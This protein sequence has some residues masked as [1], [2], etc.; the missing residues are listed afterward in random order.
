MPGTPATDLPT[1]L[2][3]ADWLLAHYQ[4]PDVLVLDASWHLPT[5]KRDGAVEWRAR[6]IPGS[7]HFDY[8]RVFCDTTNPLPRMMP[9]A[10]T[11]TAAA[12]ALGLRDDHRI[13]VYD[14]NGLFSSPRAWWMLRAAGHEQVAVLDGGLAAWTAAGGVIASGHDDASTPTGT[15]T[16]RID[17]ARFVTADHVEARLTDDAHQILDA[18]AGARF[19]AAHMP[20]ASNLPYADLLT[21]GHLRPASELGEQVG[22]LLRSDQ[23]LTCS[24]GSGVTACVIALAAT[25]AGLPN[26]ISIYDGS[27]SEWGADSTRPTVTSD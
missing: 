17:T 7:R 21:D 18:R 3:S 9:D 19:A 15:F 20:G 11:F 25:A 23:A 6:R 8:D 10:D 4:R 1:P 26:A 16:A 27:W 2:V 24:C 5:A 12:R 13:V 22:G 14:T